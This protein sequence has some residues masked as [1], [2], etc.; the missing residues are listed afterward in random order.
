MYCVEITPGTYWIF[1]RLKKGQQYY[2]LVT[3][4][5][6]PAPVAYW[7]GITIY[8]PEYILKAGDHHIKCG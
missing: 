3:T 7:I 2:C 5:D 6:N 8:I 4:L 1:T